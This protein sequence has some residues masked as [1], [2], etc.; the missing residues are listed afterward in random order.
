MLFPSIFNNVL[1]PVMRGPS[2]SHTAASLLIGKLAIQLLK[3]KPSSV[4][5]RFDP[6]GSLA[7]TYIGQG[8]AFGL[9]AGFLNMDATNS[10]MPNS[11]ALCEAEGIEIL[12]II[13]NIKDK[14]PNA[15]DIEISGSKNK[16]R[17][18]A[19]SVGGGAIKLVELNGSLI[20]D[21]F[22]YISPLMETKF[23][24]KPRPKFS[25]LDELMK[26]DINQNL[27]DYAI[28]W[29]SS[30]TESTKEN[31]SA[32]ALYIS[33]II[34]ESVINGLKGTEYSNRILQQQSH[35]FNQK[36]P[37]GELIPSTLTNNIISS[38]SAIME[39]KSSMGL[40]VAAPTAGSAGTIGGVILPV[41]ESTD[42]SSDQ[43]ARAFLAAGMIGVFIAQHGGFAAEEGGCQYECGAASGMAA[44]GLVELMGG[45]ANMAINA[46]S[47]ALQNTIGMVCDPVGNRVEVPCLGKNVMAA[48]NALTAANMT[49]AGYAHIVPLNEVIIAMQ[50]V[51][52]NMDRKLKCTCL[53]GLSL[54]P[55]SKKLDKKINTIN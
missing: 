29:E 23:K 35:L 25:S 34:K 13:E 43:I 8:T 5:V 48:V 51:G 47:M 50:E 27:S 41:A 33:K 38:V 7:S 10:D 46:A 3:E 22:E 14:H 1:G 37:K 32:R 12:Y 49:I 21:D 44:A 53:G 24:R 52:E 28:E 45:D 54:S 26:Q 55:T 16:I 2:S 18:T 17:F 40:I 9:A 20:K 31:V 42:K 6:K 19:L 15:Y 30:V 4:V 36:P 39:T 11:E